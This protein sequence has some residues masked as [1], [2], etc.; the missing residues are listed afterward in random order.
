MSSAEGSDGS[1]GI[2]SS[3]SAEAKGAA[4]SDGVTSVAESKGGLDQVSTAEKTPSDA[5]DDG[6]IKQDMI[7]KFTD[8]V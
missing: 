8:N 2:A 7:D 1:T 4:P 5:G 6:D 3:A